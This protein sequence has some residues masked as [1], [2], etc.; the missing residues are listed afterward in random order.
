MEQTKERFGV[1]LYEVIACCARV[2]QLLRMIAAGVSAHTDVS[3]LSARY[4]IE[5]DRA[6]LL[7]QAD[8]ISQDDAAKLA[9]M[10]PWLLA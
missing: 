6:K 5:K 9:R 1:D 8:A 2:Q 3:H 10:Y 4:K 7:V